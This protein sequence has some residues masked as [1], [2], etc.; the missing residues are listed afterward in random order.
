MDSLQEPVEFVIDEERLFR[1][2]SGAQ[3]L[4]K[5]LRLSKTPPPGKE[6]F[7]CDITRLTTYREN[8][9]LHGKGSNALHDLLPL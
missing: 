3:L 5:E 6:V 1:D 2:I 4:C 8:I 7:C 9:C